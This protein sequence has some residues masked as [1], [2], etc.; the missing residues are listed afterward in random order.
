MSGMIKLKSEI[1]RPPKPNRH[2]I[3][4]Q[5]YGGMNY[6]NPEGTDVE[7]YDSLRAARDE[8]WG[9][10]DRSI[11]LLVVNGTSWDRRWPLLEQIPPDPYPCPEP[12]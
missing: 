9:R 5:F 11:A 10:G 3:T 4:V 1:P 8:F 12:E 2:R 7:H 6:A